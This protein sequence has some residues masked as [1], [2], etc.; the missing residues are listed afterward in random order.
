[1]NL[2]VEDIIRTLNNLK[3]KRDCFIGNLANSETIANSEGFKE[4]LDWAIE[5]IE[6]TLFNFKQSQP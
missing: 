4:G 5:S 6:T 1:M 3:S 2:I